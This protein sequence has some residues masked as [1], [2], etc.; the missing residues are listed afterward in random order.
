MIPAVNMDSE[1][2]R[3]SGEYLHSIGAKKIHLLPYHR[4]GLA[5]YELL[6]RAYSMRETVPPDEGT[7][8]KAFGILRSYGLDVSHS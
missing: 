7:M 1:T 5:K 3:M 8:E 2:L 6:S 4:L